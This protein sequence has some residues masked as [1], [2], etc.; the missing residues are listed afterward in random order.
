VCALDDSYENG[1]TKSVNVGCTTAAEHK[2]LQQAHFTTGYVQKPEPASRVE[3]HDVR[4]WSPSLCED[5]SNGKDKDSDDEE[6]ID[7]RYRA[8][9]A[10]VLAQWAYLDAEKEA[11]EKEF[12]KDEEYA[13]LAVK[14]DEE[15]DSDSEDSNGHSDFE[16]Y[17]DHS[18]FE[19]RL[20][21]LCFEHKV[22]E[23]DFITWLVKTIGNQQTTTEE[24]C[25]KKDMSFSEMLDWLKDSLA[26]YEDINRD[27]RVM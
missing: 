27:G 15:Y 19:H 5:Y 16:I 10:K 24:Q 1:E 14:L 3:C 2:K 22:N 9:R 6:E 17:D 11:E 7:Q 4:S 25:T 26:N 23:T 12:I 18:D 8:M 20:Y 13:S 21:K